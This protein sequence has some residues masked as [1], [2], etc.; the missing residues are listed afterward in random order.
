MLKKRIAALERLFRGEPYTITFEDGSSITI[1][2]NEWDQAWKDVAAGQP[3]WIYDRLKTERDRGNIDAGGI[4]YL[5][6]AF[7]P[8]TVKEVWADFVE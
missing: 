2:L 7:S 3:N 4:I 1:G 6:E 8:K 5:M